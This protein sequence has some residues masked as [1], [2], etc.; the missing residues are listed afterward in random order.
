MQ[1]T[2]RLARINLDYSSREDGTYDG[3]S[4]QQHSHSLFGTLRGLLLFGKLS[5]Q[6]EYIDAVDKMYRVTVKDLVT[7]SGY[8]CHDMDKQT[9]GDPTSVA[10]AVC[11]ALRLSRNGR[12][13][14]FDDAVRLVRSR[15]LPCQITQCPPLSP[16]K[17]ECSQ[18]GT[19]RRYLNP[20]S[21]EMRKV[22]E[23]VIR[24]PRVKRLN[25]RTAPTGTSPGPATRSSAFGQTRVCYRSIRI[26]GG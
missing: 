5:G 7:E 8:N 19:M 1:F 3:N 18:D 21:Q 20:V 12:G 16:M 17:L 22:W 23:A 4:W 2:E 11:L 6:S 13:P 25:T 26:V 14:Y 24:Y 15:L 10:D 9:G